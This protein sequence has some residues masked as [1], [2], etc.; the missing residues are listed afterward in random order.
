MIRPG[1]ASIEPNTCPCGLVIHVYSIPDHE[2]LLVSK[3]G[4]EDDAEAIATAD[5]ELVREHDVDTVMVIY[6]GDTGQ[7]MIPPGYETG[8][9]LFSAPRCP[10]CDRPPEF[11]LDGGRQAF[12]GNDDCQVLTWDMTDDP[13]QFKARA[14]RVEWTVTEMPVSD[15]PE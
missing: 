7:R 1:P 9:Q 8:D 6:D 5:R 15:D 14:Q 13:A 11:A 3:V 2:L 10:G 12:C 4:P